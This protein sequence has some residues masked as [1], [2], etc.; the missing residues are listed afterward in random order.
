MQP[1]SALNMIQNLAVWAP[2][3]LWVIGGVILL[4]YRLE[5]RYSSIMH[6]LTERE[7]R[8]EL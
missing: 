1:Q 4:L 5:K 7:A 3:V 6:D 8:G 2:V